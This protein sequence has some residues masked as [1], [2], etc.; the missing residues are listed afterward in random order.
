MPVTV[1]TGTRLSPRQTGNIRKETT[2]GFVVYKPAAAKTAQVLHVL[3]FVPC[4]YKCLFWG[5][6][7]RIIEVRQLE[8]PGMDRS[9]LVFSQET[10]T[11]ATFWI[12][13]IHFL[14]T[15]GLF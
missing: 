4:L 8:K 12:N 15:N 6:Y 11:A 9:Y 5:F 14:A 10:V 13:N 1:L 2:F 3:P 7:L